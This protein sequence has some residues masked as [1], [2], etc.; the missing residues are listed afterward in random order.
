[1]SLTA[2]TVVGHDD[3]KATLRD[4]RAHSLLFVGPDSVGRLPT[5]RWWAALLNCEQDGAE[6]CGTCESCRAVGR[7]EHPDLLIK[8]PNATTRE[9]RAAKRPLLRIDQMVPR[10]G[11]RVDPEPL[12]RWLEGRPR[13]RRR[14]G[15]V[16][17]AHTLTAGA[18]NAFLKMLEEPP[19]WAAIVLI[20]PSPDA[21]LPTLASRC[22][23]LRFGAAPTEGFEDLAPHPGLRS[24]QRGRLLR[25]R[26][27][28]EAEEA[29]TA[30]AAEW[31]ASLDGPLGPALTASSEL[32]RVWSEHPAQGA[33]ERLLEHVRR[34]APHRYGSALEAVQEAEEAL[35][36]YVSPA[37]VG[38]ALT[39]RVR[40]GR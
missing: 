7:D 5:A 19:P 13:H 16:E 40:A 27:E 9:G 38:Q 35:S 8:T 2:A 15:I 4:V 32:M 39:L 25:A 30:A 22:V 3:I 14:V 1:M 10:E 26:A 31:V 18:G 29:V 11:P 33:A 34:D 20:A 6:P 17:D 12:S 24:G 21:V 36:A 23:T 37:L 28:P